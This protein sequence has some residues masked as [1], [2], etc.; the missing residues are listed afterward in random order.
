[1]AATGLKRRVEALEKHAPG[2]FKAWVRVIQYEDQ[3]EADAIAVHE[4]EHGP[5][6][7]CNRILRVIIRKP[8]RC[9]A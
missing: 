7:D 3:S 2:A 6:G 1:M 5:I 8:G 9:N 4:A